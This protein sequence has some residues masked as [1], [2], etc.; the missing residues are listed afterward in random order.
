V[1]GC[2]ICYK[3]ART[4][5]GCAPSCPDKRAHV[6][7]WCRGNHRSIACPQKPGWVPPAPPAKGA[8]KNG[9]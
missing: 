3:W 7:E 8:G 5:T 6:C 9:K 2:E 4:D 1:N